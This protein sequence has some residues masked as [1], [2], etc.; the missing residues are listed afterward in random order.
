[1]L[2]V[3]VAEKQ[4]SRSIALGPLQLNFPLCLAPMVGLSHAPLREVCRWYLPPGARTIWPTEMLNSRR[5]PNERLG[6][7]PETLMEPNLG[8]LPAQGN[9]M[10]QANL[11]VPQ[12]LGNEAEPIAKSI[13][14]LEAWGAVGIDINMGCPVKK[15][16]KHNYGVALMGDAHYAR[17]VVRFA[18]ESSSLPV[19]VKL[20]VYGEGLGAEAFLDFVGGLV[21]AGAQWLCLHPRPPEVKRRGHADWAQIAWLKKSISV[22]LIGNGDVQTLDDILRMLQ[23]T[24]CDLVMAGRGL[25][26]RPWLFWQ[27]GEALGFAPPAAAHLDGRMRKVPRTPEEEAQEYGRVILHLIEIMSRS[28]APPLALRKLRFYLKTTSVWLDF[29]HTLQ[30]LAHRADHISEL[31]PLIVK[32]FESPHRMF[33]RTDLR[34]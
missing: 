9:L 31:P 26:A 18:V 8:L 23:E 20:R 10:P 11:L 3:E 7:T 32:F 1:M 6:E 13:R 29:G 27:L 4:K 21:D 24:Q 25:A 33:A 15:A 14:A 2:E 12:I 5:L 30:S 16:L 19:S 34:E 17:E 22:P 28:F